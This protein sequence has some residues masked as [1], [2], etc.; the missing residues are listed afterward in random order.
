MDLLKL[1]LIFQNCYLLLFIWFLLIYQP[2][3]SSKC[4]FNY[5]LKIKVK[6]IHFLFY[7]IKWI[8]IS[9]QISFIR[10]RNWNH[11]IFHQHKILFHFNYSFSDSNKNSDLLT[12]NLLCVNPWKILFFTKFQKNSIIVKFFNY[13]F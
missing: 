11:I 6:E 2:T 10:N 1:L 7:Q 5:F 4:K 3:L 8:S 9:F 13:P 12:N